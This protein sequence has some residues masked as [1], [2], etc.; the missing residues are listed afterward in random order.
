MPHIEYNLP[1]YHM[2]NLILLLAVIAW[3]AAQVLKVIIVLLTKHKLDWR[4]IW[5]SGG[6]PSSHSAFVCACASTTGRLYGFS[7]ALFAI[8][9]ALAIVVMYDA[10]N[11]RKAAGEQAKILNYI[12][13]H[14]NEMKPD[15]FGRELKDLL[16][17]TPIQVIAGALLGVLVGM[18]G[19]ALVHP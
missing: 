18:L 8:A 4:Y 1:N 13:D 17:H 9:A 10:A 16:G 6:M 2:G 5:A 19:V 3:A 11:V 7:S 12:M 14:W 15:I